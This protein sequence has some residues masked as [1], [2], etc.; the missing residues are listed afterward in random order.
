MDF[1][2][3][4]IFVFLLLGF[5]F[6]LGMIGSI[7]QKEICQARRSLPQIQKCFTGQKFFVLKL[8]KSHEIPERF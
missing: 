2:N 6:L 5:G 3:F 7:K 4:C 1:V 8:R